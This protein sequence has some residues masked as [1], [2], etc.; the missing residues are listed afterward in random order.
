MTEYRVTFAPFQKTVV[1]PAGTTILEAAGKA[2][3]G[4]DSVCGGD[5]ICGRCK[6]IVKEGKVGGSPILL[7]SREEVRRG[8][9]LACQATV[10]GDIGSAQLS[11]GERL[12]VCCDG[13]WEMLR[14]EGIEDIL[15]AEA[16]PQTA[17][18]VMVHQANLAGGTDNISKSG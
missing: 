16:D 5:G 8:S 14:N 18:D 12:L 2:L 4:I 9:V 6:V 1:V 10:E 11:Q 15:L 17:C 7:L 13:L 3:I